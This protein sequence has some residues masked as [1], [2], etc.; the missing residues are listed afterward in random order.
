MLGFVKKT[1]TPAGNY[2]W[3]TVV[4][5]KGPAPMS[6]LLLEPNKDPAAK[7]YQNVIHDPGIPAQPIQSGR[8]P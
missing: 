5:P 7:T 6:G 3:L 1:D 8:Y 2:R 4:S